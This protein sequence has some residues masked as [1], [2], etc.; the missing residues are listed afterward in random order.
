VGVAG[1]HHQLVV[2]YE[3]NHC[4]AVLKPAGL[5]TAGD[6]TGDASLLDFARQYIKEKYRKPGNV[7]LGV[8]H[9]LDR[10]V[11]GV[12]LFAR[13]SKAAARLCE[14]FR[15]GQVTKVY[16]AWVEGVP[17][18]PEGK[19]TDSLVKDRSR[20]VVQNVPTET[21]GARS[22]TLCYRVLQRTANA[23]LLELRPRTG[24][25]HQIRVQL[26]SR[27]MPIVGDT[28]YRARPRE[29]GRIALHAVE[30][31]FEHPVRREPVT[32]ETPFPSEWEAGP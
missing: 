16:H 22:A 20:N 15:Q 8:V 28:K 6:R 27:G 29:P 10:P 18:D 2:L 9:R 32:V 31:T 5:L 14:Q 1:E 19:W 24:R 7:Y 17:H 13:T 25:S 12:V 4:L 23:T 11:S 21:A 30:L 3:D 26:A